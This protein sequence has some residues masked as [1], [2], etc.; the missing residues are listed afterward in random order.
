MSENNGNNET[1]NTTIVTST[2]FPVRLS[3]F[4]GITGEMVEDKKNPGQKKRVWSSL[5]LLPKEDEKT[6]SKIK[7][8]INAVAREKWGENIPKALKISFRDGDKEGKGGLPEGV[9]VGTE[10]YAGHYFFNAKSERGVKV[11]DQKV[12]PIL[13]PTKVKSGDYAVVSVN[14]YAWDNVNGKGISF[15]LGIVQ[16]HH[17]GEELG[18]SS[19]STKDFA[20]I[21]G[22]AGTEETEG[23][24]SGNPDDIFG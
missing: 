15:S 14:V 12:Q 18:G 20:P 16:L 21:A 22:A 23:T 13:D 1:L 3:Y 24:E 11:L 2:E 5:I 9:E 6:V 17:E 10:P 8:V 4:K 7:S 19:H